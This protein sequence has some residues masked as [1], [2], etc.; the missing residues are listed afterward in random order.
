M[1]DEQDNPDFFSQAEW[2]ARLSEN[3]RKRGELER[4]DFQ[5]LLA[6]AA[7]EAVNVSAQATREEPSL[8]GPKIAAA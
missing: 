8:F 5:L 6:W 2:F 3:S 1:C 4:A 7:Y